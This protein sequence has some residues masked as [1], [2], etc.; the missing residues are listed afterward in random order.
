MLNTL[1]RSVIY[2]LLA[3][4]MEIGGCY[5]MWLCLRERWAWW[6]GALGALLERFAAARLLPT[7]DPLSIQAG[8]LRDDM[9]MG[10]KSDYSLSTWPRHQIKAGIDLMLLRLREDFSVAPR[11][12]EIEIAP[13]AFRG[14]KTGGQ[15]SA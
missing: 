4:L 13:F 9:T 14:R 1:T 15:A 5:L 2:F 10:A 3:G 11:D 8:G 6:V 12:N 7:T